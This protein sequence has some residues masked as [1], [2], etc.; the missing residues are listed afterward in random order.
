MK[1]RDRYLNGLKQVVVEAVDDRGAILTGAIHSSI[2][3]ET[4]WESFLWAE[5][6]CKIHGGRVWYQNLCVESKALNRYPKI[7][8]IR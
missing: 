1:I 7:D 3:C 6:A 8:L 4:A 2:K 5:I